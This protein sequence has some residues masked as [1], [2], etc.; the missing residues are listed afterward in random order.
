MSHKRIDLSS[1]PEA[2]VLLSGDQAKVEIP[3]RWPSRTLRHLPVE[4][5]Q[6][7][8]VASAAI[9]KIRS[10]QANLLDP[11]DLMLL[12][13]ACY[14]PSIGRKAHCCYASLVPLQHRS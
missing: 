8:I 4:V 11:I 7:L 2:M 5:S 1:D 14:H 12:T 9:P 3:A 6:I 13:A 10:Q